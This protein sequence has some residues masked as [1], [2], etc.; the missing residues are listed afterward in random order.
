MN[1]RVLVTS[2]ARRQL[3]ECAAWWAEH[4]SAEQALRWLDGFE[5]AIAAL[6]EDPQ[7]HPLAREDGLYHLPFKCA[8]SSMESGKSRRIEQFSKC[9]AMS[10]T[11][12]LFDIWRKTIFPLTTCDPRRC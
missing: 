7:R 1:C 6:S 3:A 10:S 5:E 12:W 2:C 8:N 4:R 9:A 11:S